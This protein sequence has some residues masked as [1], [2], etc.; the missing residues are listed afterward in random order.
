MSASPHSLAQARFLSQCIFHL[1]YKAVAYTRIVGGLLP[2]PRHSA[3]W[4]LFRAFVFITHSPHARPHR[5]PGALVA[6]PHIVRVLLL[7]LLFIGP[8]GPRGRTCFGVLVS[9][10]HCYFLHTYLLCSPARACIDSKRSA[11]R[12]GPAPLVT[13]VRQLTLLIT[14]F[15]TPLT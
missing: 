8:D 14:D 5:A 12:Y 15:C 1:V 11:L 9:Y 6:L 2:S 10:C 3:H 4:I 7:P 13:R